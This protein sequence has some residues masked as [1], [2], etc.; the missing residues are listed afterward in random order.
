[1]GTYETDDGVIPGEYKVM[2]VAMTSQGGS[3]LPEDALEGNSGV[4]SVIP[5]H[6]GDLEK[7]GLRID[8]KSDEENNV[9]FTLTD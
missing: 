3:G 9:D 7:S 2:I 1:M 4:V 8:V 5:E 6:Y